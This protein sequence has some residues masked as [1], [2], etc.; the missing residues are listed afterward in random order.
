MS[1]LPQNNETLD[2]SPEYSE[3]YQENS[4]G[5]PGT[6]A[7]GGQ[8]QPASEFSEDVLSQET[9]RFAANLSLLFG[10]LSFAC[11]PGV[12]S[13][14]YFI[15]FSLILSSLGIWQARVA[16]RHGE[17][18]NVGLLLSGIGIVIVIAIVGFIVMIG[19]ALYGF[20]DAGPS[21]SLSAL[22]LR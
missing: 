4:N 15:P 19:F 16:R 10:A 2:N 7:T 5:H 18:A 21:T 6:V 11:I 22:S 9:G 13:S 14:L 12:R 3:P 17:D 1:Q 8:L 20:N